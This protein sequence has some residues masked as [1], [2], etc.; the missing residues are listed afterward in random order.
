VMMIFRNQGLLPPRPKQ[1]NIGAL[2][3]AGGGK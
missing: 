1:Y 2:E 3:P